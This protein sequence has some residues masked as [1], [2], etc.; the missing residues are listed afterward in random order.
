MVDET[1]ATNKQ[2]GKRVMFDKPISDGG[3]VALFVDERLC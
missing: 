1:E 3:V 2:S